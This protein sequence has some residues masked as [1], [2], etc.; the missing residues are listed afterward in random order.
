ME[1][2]ISPNHRHP[3]SNEMTSSTRSARSRPLILPRHRALVLTPNVETVVSNGPRSAFDDS[4]MSG[5]VRGQI[6]QVNG[7][8]YTP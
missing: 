2:G 3:G 4:P 7:G 5:Y 1:H 6:L 8:R